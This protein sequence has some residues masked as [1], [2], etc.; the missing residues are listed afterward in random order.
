MYFSTKLRKYIEDNSIKKSH[1]AALIGVSPA[2]MHKYLY[3]GS[4]PHYQLAKHITT[5]ISSITME[6]MGYD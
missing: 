5:I 1:L 2:M 6:D 3:S 4:L